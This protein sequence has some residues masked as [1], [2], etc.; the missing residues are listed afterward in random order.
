MDLRD[1]DFL[2]LLFV[3]CVD[4]REWGFYGIVIYIES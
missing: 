1:F 2:C 3:N 4:R